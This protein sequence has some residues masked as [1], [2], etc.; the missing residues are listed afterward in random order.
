[1]FSSRKTSENPSESNETR[2]A[3]VTQDLSPRFSPNHLL[4]DTLA[5]GCDQYGLSTQRRSHRLTERVERIG[6]VRW[7]RDHVQYVEREER[8]LEEEENSSM[9][10]EE[11][12]SMEDEEAGMG[13]DDNELED[14]D[15]ILPVFA[16]PGQEGISVWDL[17]GEGFLKEVAELGWRLLNLFLM[18]F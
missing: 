1:V 4:P 12:S 17:L 3:P 15:N 18:T 7:G 10:D 16:E 13:H 8:E 11:N 9:E 14:E 2:E 5:D 6:R